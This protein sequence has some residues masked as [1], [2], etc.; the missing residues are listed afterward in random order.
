ME[1]KPCFVVV[2]FFC[3]IVYLQLLTVR[4]VRLLQ[5]RSKNVAFGK[6]ACTENSYFSYTLCPRTC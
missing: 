3:I 5:D 6:A 1:K 2:F 4:V